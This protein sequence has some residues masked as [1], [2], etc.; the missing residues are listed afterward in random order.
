MYGVGRYSLFSRRRR[1]S[2]NSIIMLIK[3]RDQKSSSSSTSCVLLATML[4]L[5]F[6]VFLVTFGTLLVVLFCE[7]KYSFQRIVC[8]KK[9]NGCIRNVFD[10]SLQRVYIK[11]MK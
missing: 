7:R 3:N 5:L 10:K 4:C 1:S 6:S 8:A 11:K 2:S 9:L